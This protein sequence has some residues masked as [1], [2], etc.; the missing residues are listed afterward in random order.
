MNKCIGCGAN[1]DKELCER[2]FKIRHYNEYEQVVKD[3]EDFINILTNIPKD[4]LL[5]LVVDLFNLNDLTKI[6]NYINN[7]TILV[8]TKRDLLPLKAHEEKFLDYDYGINVK[9]KIII[10]SSKNY[11]LDNLLELINKYKKSEKVY[12]VG[13]TNAG[14]ST[15]INKILYNY[16]DSNL[17]I[18]TS[19]LPSTTLDIIKIK[20]NDNITLY[21]TP[22]ILDEGDIINYLDG[23]TIKKLITKEIKPITYQIKSNQTLII[24]DLVRI[25]LDN[26]NI[27]L[28]IPNKLK[29]ER[30]YKDINKMTNLCK[31]EL[32]VNKGS[33]IVIQGLGF[34]K[35]TKNTKITIYTL[36]KVNVYIRKSLI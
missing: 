29:V 23:K 36:D 15:L 32:K 10:S 33:D 13:Y 21:D 5:L 8:L 17:T 35:V 4:E 18:T 26:T 12:L 3:N 31:H 2:C 7:N 14:K 6:K 24:D 9:D 19:P 25:D 16:S 34:I 1:T 22:G 28:F 11:N 20:L 27:T 30:Y